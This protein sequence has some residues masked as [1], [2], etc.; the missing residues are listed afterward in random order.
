MRIN[1][2]KFLFFGSHG[3]LK[4]F[5]TK[6]QDAGLIHFVEGGQSSKE[7]PQSIHDSL[8]AL[9]ILREFPVLE[10]I[11]LDSVD[12][13]KLVVDKILTLKKEIEKL[14]E[15]G[16]VAS[17][18][19]ERIR[20]FGNFSLKEIKDIETLGKRTIQFFFANKG[21]VQEIPE[22]LF[23]VTS[24]HGLD[25]FVSVAKEPKAYEK[26][27]EM[28][29]D[30]TLFELIEKKER[31]QAAIEEKERALKGLQK[32]STFIHIALN[33]NWNDYALESAKKGARPLL[34][35][36]LF[37]AVGFV[38]E[39]RIDE[40]KNK[41][42]GSNVEMEEVAVEE[43]EQVP[44]YL[45]NEGTAKIG[46]D[47][48]K[49]YDVPSP[50]DKD[51]SLWVLSAFSLFFAM[52]IGDGGYGLLFFLSALYLRYK[53]KTPTPLAKRLLS[54]MTIL[55][56]SCIVWGFLTNS[57]FG[58]SFG[59][60]SP[61]KK[62]SLV[63]WL[64]EKKAAYH[65]ERKDD[66]YQFWVKKFS[67]LKEAPNSKS[68]LNGA[69]KDG[70]LEMVSTFSGNV[71]M[72]LALLIGSIH[73]I[74]SLLRYSKRNFAQIGWVFFIIGAYLYLPEYLQ[75]T[76]IIHY[77]TGLDVK[78]LAQNGLLIMTG[79]FAL[80]IVMSLIQN[81]WKGLLEIMNVIQIFSDILSYLRLYAL[82]LAG[83]IIGVIVNQAA[84]AAPFFIL[85]VIVLIFGH[86]LNMVLAVMGGVIHGLRL[87]FIEWYHYS[88][89]GGGKLFAPLEKKK[90]WRTT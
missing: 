85:S 35:G 89:E 6:A 87:N 65:F 43:G 17:L 36:K 48:V 60:D 7:V 1:V 3:N 52:I 57:F 39:N 72:E 23:F 44:T 83:A 53:M 21:V 5:F 26:L 69:V 30:E 63:Q 90:F 13:A 88:F 81:R 68:F 74:T 4:S 22:E 27:I 61:F 40:L 10:Q 64:I 25:Y 24:E 73:V 50:T 51:P 41:L 66:V 77:V 9:K 32:Y 8:Q 28:K 59:P 42:E 62:V 70:E 79:G 18:E 14:G 16:R 38:P 20:P 80:A 49:I 19:I 31:T 15:E 78:P 67:D 71:M 33:E 84:A 37:A 47:V 2:K 76:S 82:G 46:E 55:C 54:L 12:E 34:E 86:G 75:G 11:E 29:F 45:E 56:V 58:I